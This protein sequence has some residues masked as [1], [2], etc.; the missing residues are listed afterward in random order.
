VMKQTL[1]MI[2]QPHRDHLGSLIS[3]NRELAAGLVG[4]AA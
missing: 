1:A 3:I 2:S 4:R